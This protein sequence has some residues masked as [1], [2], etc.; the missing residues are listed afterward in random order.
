MAI[1]H[2]GSIRSNAIQVTEVATDL[3]HGN[4][5]KAKPH[6]FR[7]QPSWYAPI[8]YITFAGRSTSSTNFDMGPF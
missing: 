6:S 8:K 7:G 1:I 4:I 2:D 5:P 3:Q